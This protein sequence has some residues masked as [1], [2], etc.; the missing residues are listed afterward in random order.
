MNKPCDRCGE[1]AL[2]RT[3]PRWAG[4]IIRD[5]EKWCRVSLCAECEEKLVDNIY[6]WIPILGCYD[7]KRCDSVPG[8][9][10][11]SLIDYDA[12]RQYDLSTDAIENRDQGYIERMLGLL[13]TET[14][15]MVEEFARMILA[16]GK[17][18]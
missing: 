13:S 18:G 14:R 17:E 5:G 15:A 3:A 11:F 8:G 6:S 7:D 1:T 10:W 9:K 12:M 4:L 16:C 2:H